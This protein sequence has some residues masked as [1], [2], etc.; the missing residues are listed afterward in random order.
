MRPST[1]GILLVT[2][3]VSAQI[4]TLPPGPFSAGQGIFV[5]IVNNT[6]GDLAVPCGGFPM[7]ARQRPEGG[8]IKYPLYGDCFSAFP[9]G[10]SLIG[11]I[12][13]P[14]SGPG[15]NGSFLL[16]AYGAAVRL[17]VG[18]PS[19]SF[20]AIHVVPPGA[21]WRFSVHAWDPVA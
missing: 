9:A 4:I 19:A 11:S 14:A 5:S 12:V 16:R 1:L 20:S 15:S 8:M 7:V 2:S 18:T 13:I 3:V 21:V 6:G 10:T 17:D